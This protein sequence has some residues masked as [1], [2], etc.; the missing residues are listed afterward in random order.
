VVVAATLVFEDRWGH[1]LDEPA[2]VVQVEFPE[3]FGSL[4]GRIEAEQGT[5]VVAGMPVRLEA[6]EQVGPEHVR[7]SLL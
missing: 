4:F 7:F 5:V 6:T 3:A 1:L 2:W